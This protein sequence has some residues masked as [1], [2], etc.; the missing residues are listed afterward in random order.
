M[1]MRYLFGWR[2]LLDKMLSGILDMDITFLRL[3]L[4]RASMCLHAGTYMGSKLPPELSP[5][6]YHHFRVQGGWPTEDNP[7]SDFLRPELVSFIGQRYEVIPIDVHPDRQPPPSRI[8]SSK[9]SPQPQPNGI[10]S[11]R[12]ATPIAHWTTSPN[13]CRRRLSCP[14]PW[15]LSRIQL[16]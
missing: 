10:T 13:L 15:M 12:L 5:N 6:M 9:Q 1:D 2:L 16:L 8:R 4:T 14:Q 3:F 7:L 11:R